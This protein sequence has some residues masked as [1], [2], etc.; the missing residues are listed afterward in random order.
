MTEDWSGLLRRPE[1]QFDRSMLER[2]VRGRRVL[3]TGAGGSLGSAL[4][5]ELVELGAQELLLL[6]SHEAS[7]VQ[8]ARLLDSACP[9]GPPV[10]YILADIRDRQKLDQIFRDKPISTIFHLA[11]Y[12]QVPLAEDNLDQVIAVNV[13]GT[14]NVYEAAM[15]HGAEVIAFPS[16]DK[17]V[18][19]PSVYGATKRVAERFLLA[20]GGSQNRPGARVVR[21]VNVFGTQ[22]SVVELFARQARSGRPLWITDERMDRYWMTM[23]E[24]IGLLL[25][26]A[27][28]SVFEGIYMLDVGAPVPIIETA[29]AVF[30]IVS[31]SADEPQVVTIGARPG[32]RL[33]EQLTSPDETVHATDV[34]GLWVIQSAYREADRDTW[35]A[36]LDRLRE[37]CYTRG[38]TALR[39]WLFAVA[40][41]ASPL[42]VD[43]EHLDAARG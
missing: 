1:I 11:A 19:P 27:G 18:N 38:G 28:R 14:A 12:K 24:A 2:A 6:D 21:L 33:H 4:S 41:G 31:G 36:A 5:R 26:A 13:L 32:E 34:P 35:L 15:R 39:A 9:G 17:A 20:V 10:R 42:A 30:R 29:R 40:A 7:L 23:R 3:V 37:W 16:S 43:P 25:I 8:L 22:G